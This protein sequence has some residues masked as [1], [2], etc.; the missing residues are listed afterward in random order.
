ME[1]DHFKDRS[2]ESMKYEGIQEGD[3]VFICEK[4]MQKIACRLEHLTDGYVVK[5]LT[6]DDHPRGI[7]VMID[8]KD[9]DGAYIVGRVVYLVKDGKLVLNNSG[10]ME[11]LSERQGGR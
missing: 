2:L 5:K 9:E 7:K 4:D 6:R 11:R 3:R 8:R 10:R 1:K